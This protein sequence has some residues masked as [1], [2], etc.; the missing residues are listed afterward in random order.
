MAIRT[1]NGHLVV[2][3]TTRD[4]NL[5]N[6]GTG[7]LEASGLKSENTKCHVLGTGPI[8]CNASVTLSING[9]GSGKVYYGGSPSKITNRSLG[10]K[11][12]SVDNKQ[13]IE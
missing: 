4:A 13:E 2:T 12:I 9:A 1:G 5:K 10:I 11:A 3:G 8:D 6:V 7:T